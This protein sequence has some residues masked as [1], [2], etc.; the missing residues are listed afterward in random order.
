MAEENVATV[1]NSTAAA[2]PAPSGMV[3]ASQAEPGASV[4]RAGQPQATGTE[5]PAEKP[6]NAGQAGFDI[7]K[8][9]GE[10]RKEFTRVTQENARA[11]RESQAALQELNALKQSQQKLTEAIAASTRKPV[12]PQKFMHDLQTQGPEALKAFLQEEI[13]S[14]TAQLQQA[15]LEQFNKGVLMEA[16]VEKLHRRMDTAN[17]PDFAALEP[18][19]QEIA[20]SE[21][22]PI[23]WKQPISVIYDTL[24][25]LAREGNSESAV[26]A[27]EQF[28]RRT[29]ERTLGKE[30]QAAVPTG[31]KGASTVNPKE[32]KD[33]AQ[34]RQYFVSQVG[35]SEY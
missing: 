25:K 8:S 11:R 2:S 32:I 29:A 3:P 14:G 22:C 35:E 26:A 31:G 10:L 19:M 13:K 7:E 4:E 30:A 17:Y 9:Y 1:D 20:D 18:K 23:D 6:G 12:D 34:L 27:A 5:T 21:N 15:Y 16:Q 28:G 33:L 24:Y